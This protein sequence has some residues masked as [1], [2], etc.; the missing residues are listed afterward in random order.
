[1]LVALDG[2]RAWL[3]LGCRVIAARYIG[4][5]HLVHANQRRP[6]MAIGA[7]QMTPG[8]TAEMY[9]QV[10]EKMFGVRSSE[11]SSVDAPDG[12]IMHSAGPTED[13]WY[14]YDVWESEEHLQRFVQE[15]LMPALQELNAP[16]G[17]P[18]QIYQ[19]H[20]LVVTQNARVS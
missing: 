11:F 18:P 15:R 19:I 6:G 3:R 10:G 16:P 5:L 7:L 20:N 17:D 9:E 14:V 1:V 13:G 12:L 4:S 8:G 2:E